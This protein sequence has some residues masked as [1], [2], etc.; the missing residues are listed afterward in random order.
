MNFFR[1][2]IDHEILSTKIFDI[3]DRFHS[4]Q[5]IYVQILK[6]TLDIAHAEGG[7]LIVKEEDGF[8]VRACIAGESFSFRG[9]E[10]LSFIHWLK[11]HRR[12]MTR[13]DLLE[14]PE[15]TSIKRGGLAYFVQFRAEV[16]L[17]LFIGG[18]LFGLI[19]LGSPQGKASYPRE[20]LK[21]LTWMGKQF[22][23]VLK[24]AAMQET[25]S[26]Q[27]LEI[28]ELKELKHQM[29]AN[30]SHEL[31]TP[32][33]GI[34]G[35]AEL[36]MEGIDGTLNVSQKEY[37]REILGNSQNLIQILTTLIHLARLESGN[38]AL[39]VQQFPLEPIVKDLIEEISFAEGLDFKV[40]LNG[41]MPHIYGDNDLVR[42]VF[43][44]LLENAAK[45]TSEGEIAISGA[46]KG[47]ML[48]ICI[49]DTGIGIEKEKLEKI[50]EGFVQADG[51]I[52]R[53]FSGVGLGLTVTRK[54]VEL[55]GGRLWVHSRP[56]RG[57][58]FYF[59]LPLKPI[60]IR[61]KELAA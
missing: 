42:Q 30:L 9:E 4:P 39:N 29:L 20:T 55:H 15:L 58:R 48:E 50:F 33:T 38:V 25:L 53:H 11:K 21:I 44:H 13:Q 60:T 36:L 41:G 54:L 5:D 12:L 35:F 31:R 16:C 37:V 24:N 56:G 6:L 45:Y 43:K 51:S 26:K 32:L 18:N 52:T 27:T 3:L 47:E 61:H 19:N 34:I 14:K 49:A 28:K 10:T 22:A 59:T 7:S 8:S 40:Y 46:K 2:E 1:S 17:P 57:S 23:F